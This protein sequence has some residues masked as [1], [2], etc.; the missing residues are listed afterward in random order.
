[1][2][3]RKVKP[4]LKKGKSLKLFLWNFS[5]VEIGDKSLISGTVVKN[6]DEENTKCKNGLLNYFFS[7]VKSYFYK[8]YSNG[9]LFFFSGNRK[10]L[11]KTGKNGEFFQIADFKVQNEIKISTGEIGETDVLSSD[12]YSKRFRDGGSEIE[13]I[14]DVDDTILESHTLKSVKRINNILFVKPDKRKIIE[15]SRQLAIQI[16]DRGGRVFYVSKSENNLYPLIKCFIKSNGFPEGKICLTP[17]KSL[18]ALFFKK[19]KKDIK[20]EKIELIV[21]LSQKK[22][23]ILLGDDTQQD[24]EIYTGLAD[25]YPDKILMIYIRR[26]LKHGSKRLNT[27]IEL[28]NNSG[29]TFKLFDEKIDIGKELE[30]LKNKF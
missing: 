21:S 3:Y 26:T 9:T 22:K 2:K 5:V 30:F 15:F 10:L 12:D 25:K 4:V 7:I 19:K 20:H 16:K 18:P 14:T 6:I 1:M 17:F 11:L 29:V 24:V 27:K 13:L 28:L 23:F 8:T